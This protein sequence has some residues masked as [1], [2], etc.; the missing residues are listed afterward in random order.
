[1]TLFEKMSRYTCFL[2]TIY[3]RFS[4]VLLEKLKNLRKLASR[5]Q[6]AKIVRLTITVAGGVAG[7]SQRLTIGLHKLGRLVVE[8]P[9]GRHGN[10]DHRTTIQGIGAHNGTD[11]PDWGQF[12]GAVYVDTG[13][14][15]TG[16]RNR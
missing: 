11:G 3:T 7:A 4:I 12:Q 5:R 14:G 9:T 6:G 1:M 16:N 15:S 10:L 8:L 13:K 2:Y